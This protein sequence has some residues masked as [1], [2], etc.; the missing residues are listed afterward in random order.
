MG[1]KTE[2]GLR[3]ELKNVGQH[4]PRRNP[5]AGPWRGAYPGSG[6]P[7]L[8]HSLPPQLPGHGAHWH[9][10][11]R[12]SP[13]AQ[14]SR[15]HGHTWKRWSPHLT[16]SPQLCWGF[17]WKPESWWIW[18]HSCWLRCSSGSSRTCWPP[19]ERKPL[20]GW[21]LSWVHAL[22]MTHN[23]VC[24]LHGFVPS[25]THAPVTSSL[26]TC[27]RFTGWWPH[28]GALPMFYYMIM[29][30][31]AEPG[32]FTWEEMQSEVTMP[33]NN[34]TGIWTLSAWLNSFLIKVT[35]WFITL[36]KC[37]I[38]FRSFKPTCLM[39]ILNVTPCRI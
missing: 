20:W 10:G 4:L 18:G 7:A 14:N 6:R 29:T 25:Y 24:T 13:C 19:E 12:H 5:G 38:D 36:Q 35:H 16:S 28:T 26:P 23:L 3:G 11:Q 17:Q 1:D 27:A 31:W 2:N 30:W 34:R 21:D 39:L 33:V 8:A 9:I 37:H 15:P 32:H 22:L